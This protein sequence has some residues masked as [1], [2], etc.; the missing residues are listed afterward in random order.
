MCSGKG[1]RPDSRLSFLKPKTVK[2]VKWFLK[3]ASYYGKIVPGYAKITAYINKLQPKE[4]NFIRS[5]SE[6]SG[7]FSGGCLSARVEMQ[8]VL[9]E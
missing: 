7:D 4:E 2:Q 3:L 1:V 5:E 8:K 9:I 6:E